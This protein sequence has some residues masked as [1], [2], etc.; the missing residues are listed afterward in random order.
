M[1]NAEREV[2]PQRA[3]PSDAV[4][5]SIDWIFE[6]AWH[7]ERLIARLRDGG[8]TIADDRGAPAAQ[9][10][11]AEAADVLEPAID[12]VE[13]LVDGIWTSMPFGAEGPADR[14]PEEAALPLE[15]ET[16]RGFV[17]IDLLELDGQR[18]Y[19]VPLMER[20]RLLTS[21]VEERERVRVSEA[22]RIPLDNWLIAWRA[23]GFD[24][25]VAKH[26]NSR[27]A[28]GEMSEDWLLLPTVEER[29]ASFIAGV[30][31]SRARRRMHIEDET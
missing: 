6:P 26:V 11:A 5:Q 10:L 7:G 27:Y 22:V 4:V 21:V 30:W 23:A 20:R 1:T 28:P 25:Y 16:R 14:L 8:V 9:D 19:D 24:H 13:A 18:L 2:L 31:P 29:G 17:A 12:A 3:K 15:N